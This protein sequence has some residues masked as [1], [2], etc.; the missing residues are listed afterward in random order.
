MLTALHRFLETPTGYNFNAWLTIRGARAALHAA[1]PDLSGQRILDVGCGPGTFAELFEHCDY[2]G[3][4]INPAYI[5]AAQRQHGNQRFV[6]GDATRL[7][8][9]E[10]PFDLVLLNFFLHHLDEDSAVTLLRALR[11]L[12]TPRG[13]MVIHEPLHPE[14]KRGLPQ[15]LMRLDRGEHYRPLVQLRELVS[16]AGLELDLELPYRQSLL[17][18]PGSFMATLRVRGAP[19]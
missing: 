4:D 13:C 1:L 14:G 11:G 8:L 6:T 5:A 12:L 15:L 3:V 16:R 2:L 19:S 18:I 7:A 17:G 10:P 9:R